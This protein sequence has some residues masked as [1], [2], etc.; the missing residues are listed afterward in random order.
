MPC[1]VHSICGVFSVCDDDRAQLCGCL[2]G[3]KPSP[4]NDWDLNYLNG[5]CVRKTALQCGSQGEMDRFIKF[6]STWLP[7]HSK[8]VVTES[9]EGCK[10]ACLTNCSCT[11]YTYGGGLCSIWVG[12][13]NNIRQASSSKS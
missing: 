1:D 2:Q 9:A 13:L 6:A 4:Q 8:A 12:D 10:S 7:R 3:F 5:G 11:A